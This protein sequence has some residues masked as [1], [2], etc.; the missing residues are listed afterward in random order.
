MEVVP[1]TEHEYRQMVEQK[2]GL[3]LKD[4]MYEVCIRSEMDTYE[5]AEELG[6]PHAIFME[7]RAAYHFGPF[8][9]SSAIDMTMGQER[10]EPAS[11]KSLDGFEELARQMLELEKEKHHK[12]I[13]SAVNP[14]DRVNIVLWESVLYCLETYKDG[15]LQKQHEEL[16]HHLKRQEH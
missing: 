3:S 12:A 10:T 8:P 4:L 16:V 9:S 14:L 6:V 11:E 5:A 1:M 15:T 13:Q 2:Y 7:W